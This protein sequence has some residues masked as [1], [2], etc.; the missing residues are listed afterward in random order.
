MKRIFILIQ[1]LGTNFCGWQHQPELRTVQGE[2]ERAIFETTGEQVAVHSSSRTDAGVH[3]LAMPAHFDTDT[4]ILPE[5]LYKALNA[6]LPDDIRVLSSKQVDEHFH[7]RFD[8]KEKTYEYHF[9]VSPAPL[10]YYSTTS[11]WITEP[12]DFERAKGAASAFLGTHDFVGFA[13]ARTEV[14]STV[15]TITKISLTRKKPN[16][17]CLSVTGDGF[18]YNMV[19][20]IAGTLI[21]I[22][23]GKINPDDLPAIIESKDRKRAGRTAQACGLVLKSV[24]Y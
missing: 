17:Y 11:A 3:A 14:S 20:I 23:Q 1:Y 8:V 22:G 21:E 6:H 5:N 10:P 15:R 2:I 24:K 9:Y 13:S 16:H 12:F 4:R 19:R 18:L 7:A